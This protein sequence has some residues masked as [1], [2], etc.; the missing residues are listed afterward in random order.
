MALVLV[1]TEQYRLCWM[2]FSPNMAEN[3]VQASVQ[4]QSLSENT[5]L[6][7]QVA[8]HGWLCVKYG[9]TCYSLWAQH[10]GAGYVQGWVMCTGK[11]RGFDPGR[12]CCSSDGGEK[13]KRPSIGI[14]ALV[15]DPRVVQIRS[16]SLWRAHS[17]GVASLLKTPEIIELCT[18]KYG[19][20]L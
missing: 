4:S 18:R 16:P 1:I 12:S 10:D 8:L 6:D 5:S 14:S 15:K 17:P 11:G 2:N 3:R 13:P 19:I 7:W 9:N 20:N